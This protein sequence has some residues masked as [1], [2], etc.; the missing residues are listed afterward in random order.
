MYGSTKQPGTRQFRHANGHAYA[1]QRIGQ[2]GQ[3]GGDDFSIVMG[4]AADL[5]PAAVNLTAKPGLLD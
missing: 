1:A 2:P 4:V 5:V 3:C